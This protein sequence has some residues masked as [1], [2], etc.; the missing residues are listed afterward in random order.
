MGDSE[1]WIF[2]EWDVYLIIPLYEMWTLQ[3]IVSP[4]KL[5]LWCKNLLENVVVWMS[6]YLW[7]VGMKLTVSCE[8]GLIKGCTL[9][10]L[11]YEWLCLSMWLWMWKDGSWWS[12]QWVVKWEK[13]L[14]APEAMIFLCGHSVLARQWC[15]QVAITYLCSHGMLVWQG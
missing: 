14:N 10:M 6:W 13:A 5:S 7:W 15:T 3:L 9:W 8:L 11:C 1:M 12:T 4:R 2:D